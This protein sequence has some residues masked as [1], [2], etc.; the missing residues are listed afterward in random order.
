MTTATTSSAPF[1]HHLLLGTGDG[2]RVF[3]TVDWSSDGRLSMTGVEGPMSN[4]DARGSCGQILMSYKEYDGRGHT[5]LDSITPADGW[6]HD[7]IRKLFDVWRVWHLN[8]MQAGCEHQRAAGWTSCPGHYAAG[9]SACKGS[10]FAAKDGA[11]HKSACAVCG[12][13]GL[14]DPSYCTPEA[15]AKRDRTTGTWST[16]STN[17]YR[18]TADRLSER[19]PEC[20]YAYGS[21][22][23]KAEVPAEIV[24][25][26]RGLPTDDGLSTCWQR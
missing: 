26:L 19:C 1:K 17:S 16:Y 21:R 8:D 25:W 18:C 24:E 7:S 9:C 23:L 4:G 2:G 22:W 6:T 3:V 12:G 20:G 11:D 14:K 10:G 15:R 13:V 5:T